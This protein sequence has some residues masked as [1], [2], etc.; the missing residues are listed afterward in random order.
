MPTKVGVFDKIQIE[1]IDISERDSYEEID[2]EMIRN[3]WEEKVRGGGVEPRF[4]ITPTYQIDD[5][6]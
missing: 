5:N 6:G 3:I 4:P 2:L 1:D